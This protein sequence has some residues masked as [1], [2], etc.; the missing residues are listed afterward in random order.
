MPRPVSSS[1]VRSASWPPCSAKTLADVDEW[2]TEMQLKSMRVGKVVLYTTGLTDHERA[3]TGVE[4]STA[5]DAA[6]A[7]SLARHGDGA[8]AVIPEGPYV[9]PVRMSRA[10]QC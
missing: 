5:L 9:V 3:I 7:D 8:I 10:E 1:S 2:Q 4:I 6:I